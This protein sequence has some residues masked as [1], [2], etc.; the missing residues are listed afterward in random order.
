MVQ[1]RLTR[2]Q[3]DILTRPAG[4]VFKLWSFMNWRRCSILSDATY[5]RVLGH[6][7]H[8]NLNQKMLRKHLKYDNEGEDMNESDGIYWKRPEEAYVSCC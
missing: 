7:M 2:H 4:H 6:L 1:M 3:A 8:D 5:A